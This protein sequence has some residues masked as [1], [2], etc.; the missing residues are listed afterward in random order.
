MATITSVDGNVIDLGTGEVVGKAAPSTPQD[1]WELPSNPLDL[2]KQLSYGFNAALF[3]LP[4][5]GV[6]AFGRALGYKDEQVKTLTKIFNTGDTGAKNS[7]Q[8]Y[9]RAIGEGIGANLPITG[10]LGF[11]AKTQAA[12]RPLM[13]DASVLQRVA[14]EA[15]DMVKRNPKAAVLADITAGGTYGAT[16]EYAKEEGM[17]PVA[18]ELFPLATS[19]LAP[20]AAAIVGSAASK[21][22]PSALAARYAKELI[23][24]SEQVL[25]SVG[26]EII[27]ENSLL[28]RPFLPSLIKRAELVVGRTLNKGEVQE[29]LTASDKLIADLGASGLSLNTA[30]RTLLPD[31]ILQNAKVV[32]QMTPEEL[33]AELARRAANK[34]QFNNIIESFSPKSTL[35]VEDALGKV[36][37]D[38]ESLQTSLMDNIAMD[39]SLEVERLAG[40]FSLEDKSSLGNE[41]R[42]TI[43][44]GGEKSFFNLRNV[45]E[46]MG[47]RS[48][49]TK[50][51]VPLPT[52]ESNGISRYPSFDIEKPVNNI[53]EKY[54]IFSG[55]IRE[56]NP[57]LVNVLGRYK[58]LQG[59]KAADAF[60]EELTKSI[61]DLMVATERPGVAGGKPMESFLSP[62]ESIASSTQQDL[63]FRQQRETSAKFLTDALLTPQ[64][65]TKKRPGLADLGLSSD[66]QVELLAKSYSLDP[67]DLKTAITNAKEVAS[68][69]GKVDIN[70]PEAVE[71]LQ[72]STEARNDAIK[73]FTDSQFAGTGRVA[74]QR[75]LDKATALHKDIET[76]VL[77]AVPKMDNQYKDF[78]QVYN[79]IYGDT[80]D[81]YLPILLNAKRGTGEFLVPNE[82]VVKQAFSSG[83]NMREMSLMLRGNPQGES[84]LTR[85]TMDWLRGKSILD[86]EGIIDPSKL[87]AVLASN[88]NIVNALP[89]TIQQGLRN[90]LE[91]GKA[92]AAR[93]GQLEARKEAAVDSELMTLISKATREGADPEALL[94]RALKDPADMNMLVKAMQG[95]PQR[96]EALRRAIYKQ[97]TDTEGK[98]SI[99]QF[100]ETAN[101]KALSYLFDAEQLKNLKDLGNMQ[102]RILSDPGIASAAGNGFEATNEALQ[103]VLG[104]S[105]AGL[106]GIGKAMMEKRTGVAWNTAYLLTRFMSRQEYSVIDRVM[107]HA[108]ADP[109]FASAIAQ[110]AA[111]KEPFNIA[112]KLQKFFTP[113]GIYLP[114]VIYNAPRRALA[115]DVAEELQ[116][117]VPAEPTAPQEAPVVAPPPMQQPSMRQAPMAPPAPPKP[118]SQQQLQQFNQRYPAPPTKGFPKIGPGLSTT[119]PKAGGP[120]A[121]AMYQALFPRDTLGQAIEQNKQ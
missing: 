97:A 29:A 61:T 49:F 50:D 90:E 70:F 31:F 87:N 72:A 102:S 1:Q 52:R 30:E 119:P 57:T 6:S 73:L 32:K 103:R 94:N 116:G 40:R 55:P 59:K 37:A 74:A 85:A 9:A 4:D 79:D 115:T 46:R 76:M 109:A 91:A 38:S 67:S 48:A 2:A 105:V 75:Q 34:D 53:L 77:D 18:S 14:R 93:I 28:V 111:E 7:E 86:K 69:T 17:G 101:P 82:A 27:N 43:L 95:E 8:R 24:P 83:E 21:V 56:Q 88:K 121:A 51:G 47:L 65:G 42:N 20:G 13:A 84:L 78:K 10:I 35:S 63:A 25:S 22:A 5:A 3:A 114:E 80:Y 110:K 71:L 100:L 33:K 92:Y 12:S 62:A 89:D 15:M 118:T 58:G 120:N 54:R 68:K 98:A 64:A 96:L 112:K 23:S 99:N 81:K 44:G 39:K 26:K 16:K 106:T 104:T 66:K 117:S 107:Q 113:Q 11:A 36:K 60:S 19:I 45:A 108:I 41:I